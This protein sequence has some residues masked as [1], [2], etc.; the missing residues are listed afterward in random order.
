MSLYW[1]KEQG[2]PQGHSALDDTFGLSPL[3]LRFL[4]FWAQVGSWGC[5]WTS[6]HARSSPQISM[7]Q[8]NNKIGLYWDWGDVTLRD[9]LD[10]ANPPSEGTETV[11]TQRRA[12]REGEKGKQTDKQGKKSRG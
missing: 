6:L 1:N 11:R 10:R 7:D 4:G 8:G 5:I 2:F 12:G 9:I 3:H